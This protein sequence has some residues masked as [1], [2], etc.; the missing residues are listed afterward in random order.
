MR[1]ASLP[2]RFL[3]SEV[4]QRAG[5]GCGLKAPSSIPGSDTDLL[6]RGQPGSHLA[7]SAS[8]PLFTLPIWAASSSGQ[9]L[10]LLGPYN[11]WQNRRRLPD[12]TVIS[13]YSPEN[14]EALCLLLSYSLAARRIIKPCFSVICC[15]AFLEQKR[16]PYVMK[17]GLRSCL[18]GSSDCVK[19][20]S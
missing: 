4:V 6:H 16:S 5:P 2:L 13:L 10:L 18:S 20:N 15:H 12:T 17:R 11:S 7:A 8:Q 19:Q 1:R 9:G 3:Q 14:P